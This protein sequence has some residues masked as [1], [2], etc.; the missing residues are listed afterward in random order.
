MVWEEYKSATG[1]SI[2]GH[3]LSATGTVNPSAL[4]LA[5]DDASVVNYSRSALTYAA[6]ADK[7][8][9]VSR[10]STPTGLALGV[11]GGLRPPVGT[12]AYLPLVGRGAP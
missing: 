2:I 6:T 11:T 1:R 12:R 7:Y 4:E 5:Y 9:L 10:L 3:Q 8:I